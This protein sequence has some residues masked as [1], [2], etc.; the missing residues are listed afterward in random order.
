MDF[1]QRQFIG[2]KSS[3]PKPE[4]FFDAQEKLLIVATPWGNPSGAKKIVTTIADYY[5]A[6]KTDKEA[7]SP[8][9]RLDYLSTAANN[10]RI[11]TLVGNEMLYREENRNEYR[12]A[13][14]LFVGTY[15]E[16]ELVW[17]QLGAPSVCLHRKGEVLLPLR[18]QLDLASEL[19]SSL[20]ALPP[21]PSQ[22]IGISPEPNISVQSF[23]PRETDS[24]V[25]VSRSWLPGK[26]FGLEPNIEIFSQLSKTLAEHSDEPFWLGHWKISA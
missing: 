15:S 2:S 20:L 11:A 6:T 17:I 19:E 21:L 23:C 16:N 24:L 26:I 4:V 5:L 3:L 14:E 7:T 22:L 12:S 25:L 18:V 9:R 10:L 1:Q 8:F 13:A